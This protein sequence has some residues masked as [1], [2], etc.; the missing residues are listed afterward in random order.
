MSSIVFCE[1]GSIFNKNGLKKHIRSI[2]HIRWQDQKF[3]DR[4]DD[5]IPIGI[6]TELFFA[7][8]SIT[9]PKMEIDLENKKPVELTPAGGTAGG[10]AVPSIDCYQCRQLKL[11]LQMIGI[12]FGIASFA[13]VLWLIEKE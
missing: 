12:S 2:K 8:E 1:C 13:L 5:V 9:E 11:A 7:L 6:P 3:A 10:T 4:L